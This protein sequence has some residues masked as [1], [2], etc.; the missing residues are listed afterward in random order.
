MPFMWGV[1]FILRSGSTFRL[2]PSDIQAYLT[3][4]SEQGEGD[5]LALLD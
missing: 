5:K 4:H 1:A 2:C 3:L